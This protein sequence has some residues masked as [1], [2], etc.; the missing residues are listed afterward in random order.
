MFFLTFYVGDGIEDFE[1]VKK[2]IVITYF[3]EGIYGSK[4]PSNEGLVLF[5]FNG[6]ILSLLCHN[7][8]TEYQVDSYL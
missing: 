1:V 3:D 8:F 4:G 6:Q 2:G 5:D 7:N